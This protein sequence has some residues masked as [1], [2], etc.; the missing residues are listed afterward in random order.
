MAAAFVIPLSVALAWAIWYL[1]A[2]YRAEQQRR[3]PTRHVFKGQGEA[4]TVAELIEDS[5]EQGGG[6]RLNWSEE[7][8]ARAH[9]RWPGIRPYV[10]DQLGTEIMRSAI[11]AEGDFPTEILPKIE[12]DCEETG[13]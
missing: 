4:V 12:D 13:E 1:V 2:Q 8:E 9:S 11:N 5:A 3:T 10:Q 7:D 6:V